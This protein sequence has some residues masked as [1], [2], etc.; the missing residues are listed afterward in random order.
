MALAVRLYGLSPAEAILGATRHA[1]TS[2][3]LAGGGVPRARGALA[4]G[5]RADVVVWD[6]PHENAIIQPWGG[7]RTRLV[8]RD[9]VRIGGLAP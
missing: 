9:G 7:P 3:G 4:P 5:A 8:L 6:L 2:L 1:A